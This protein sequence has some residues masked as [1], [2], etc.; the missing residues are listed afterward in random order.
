[1]QQSFPDNEVHMQFHS[2]VFVCSTTA[3]VFV[4]S[5]RL[6]FVSST[7][8][9]IAAASNFTRVHLPVMVGLLSI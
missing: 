9:Q 3:A 4:C 6:K 7:C 5:R 8:L 2:A 1:M